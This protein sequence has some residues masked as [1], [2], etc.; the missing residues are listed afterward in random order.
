[1]KFLRQAC[2]P[3]LLFG[4]E[5]FTLTSSQLLKLERCQ[6][7]FLRI[8]FYAPKFAP[9]VLLLKLSN[10]NSVEAEVDIKK[11]LIFGSAHYAG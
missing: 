4:S 8:I 10:L 2:L 9:R 7:W 5:L 6:S 3:T 1:M 11:P